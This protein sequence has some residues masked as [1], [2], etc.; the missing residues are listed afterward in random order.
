MI[1]RKAEELYDHVVFRPRFQNL[2]SINV[3]YSN[4]NQLNSPV[5]SRSNTITSVRQT[6]G[7]GGKKHILMYGHQSKEV[8]YLLD[9]LQ[10]RKEH[11]NNNFVAK[12]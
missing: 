6:I 7:L 2:E 11:K 10:D 5:A 4:R 8:I 12:V 1:T 9:L 3:W